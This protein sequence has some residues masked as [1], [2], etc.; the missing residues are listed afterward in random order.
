MRYYLIINSLFEHFEALWPKILPPDLK[1]VCVLFFLLTLYILNLIV[2]F[3]RMKNMD[4][5][6][7]STSRTPISNIF[8]CVITAHFANM[9]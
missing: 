7:N 3:V 1:N 6:Y 8:I 9:F 5:P 4:G 2:K